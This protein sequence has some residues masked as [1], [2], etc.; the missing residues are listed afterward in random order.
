MI[1]VGFCGQFQ[2]AVV[3]SI[4]FLVPVQRAETVMRVGWLWIDACGELGRLH[5]SHGPCLMAL[6]LAKFAHDAHSL[7]LFS[8]KDKDRFPRFDLV[9]S[10][11]EEMLCRWHNRIQ[12]RMFSFGVHCAETLLEKVLECTAGIVGIPVS[13]YSLPSDN[14]GPAF[15]FGNTHSLW[16]CWLEVGRKA[17]MMLTVRF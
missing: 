14:P 11:L 4:V 8:D 1:S 7:R 6:D 5:T 9:F 3:Y 13:L 2:V 10:D 12:R 15:C 16:T 17:A